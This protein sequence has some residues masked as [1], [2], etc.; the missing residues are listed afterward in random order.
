MIFWHHFLVLGL[1]MKLTDS[2]GFVD[3]SAGIPIQQK[4]PSQLFLARRSWRDHALHFAPT[5]VARNLG[6]ISAIELACR[7]DLDGGA[8]SIR[9]QTQPFSGF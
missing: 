3:F 2:A 8:K 5:L 7:Q 4:R 9:E 6:L 1:G